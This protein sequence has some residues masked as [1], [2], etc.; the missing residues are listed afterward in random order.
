MRIVIG[1]EDEVA[2]ALAEALMTE[3]AVFL[4]CPESAAGPRLDRLDIEPIYSQIASSEA[5]HQAHVEECDLFIACTPYD[6]QNLV[7]CLVAKRL[8]AKSTVCFLFRPDFRTA[9]D[10]GGL[11]AGS[12][13]IDHVIRPSEQLAREILR[14]ATVPGALDVE[15]FE[16]G[17]VQL[18]RHAVEEGSPITRARLMDVGVPPE[19]VLVMARRG[20]DIFVPRGNTLMKAGD[21][22][23]AMGNPTAMNRLLYRYLR[24]DSHGRDA[25]RVT[26]VGAGEVGVA[27]ALGL[28]DLG[29]HVRL[30]EPRLQRCEE[31]SRV[32]NSLVLHGDG[33]NLDLLESEQVSDDSVFIAV[34]D[35]DERNLLISLIAKHLGVPRIITRAGSPAN[36]RL[37]EKVG[38]DVVRSAQGAA[39]HAVVRRIVASRDELLA[40]LEHGD[41]MVLELEIPAGVKPTS[42][43]DLKAPEFSIIGAV[44]RS[45]SAI[46]PKGKDTIQGGDRVLVFC[47]REN[48]EE[49]RDFFHNR[50]ERR[51]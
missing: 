46:I 26:I 27:V 10:G 51:S 32:L 28:E 13:G 15:A 21:K 33:A 23:T 30:I 47:I 14:I 37:F 18:F 3:H 48:E 40:E 29:W 16:G 39:I 31:V 34:T 45:G 7:A 25:R 38:I 20:D 36:E 6:E 44:L 50:L 41:A 11:V 22:V 35:N 4:V 49:T 9:I 42:L 5:L 8:G 1:G 17:K 24:A 43:G 19:V 2:F 12:I